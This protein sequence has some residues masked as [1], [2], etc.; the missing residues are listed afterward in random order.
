MFRALPEGKLA[1][2]TEKDVKG[3]VYSID[4]IAGKVLA[5]INSRVHIFSWS[6]TQGTESKYARSLI[7]HCEHQGHILALRVA[8][9]GELIAVGDLMK[10]V[11]LLAYRP[12]EQ[13]IEEVAR[14]YQPGWVAS[15]CPVSDDTFLVAE[16]A[17]NVF[18]LTRNVEAE[19]DDERS[20]LALSAEYHIGEFVNAL[21]P[22]SLV[23]RDPPAAASLDAALPTSTF[24]WGSSSGAV[25]V[26]ARINAD[27][28]Q[29]FSKVQEN[30]SKVIQGVG[31][32]SHSFWRSFSNERKTAPAKNFLDGDLIESFL[33]LRPEKQAIVV[34]G[35]GVSVEDLC[36]R[37]EAIQRATH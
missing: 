21:R 11:T 30:I 24:I 37:I 10:S 3:A 29:F 16:N 35:L 1:L 28:F 9:V 34:S 31:G 4:Q 20:R 36:K 14:D 6:E 8:A 5:A 7:S 13:R 17:Y 23:A 15:L 18:C 32:F 19:T 25:G 26:I 33:D 22:G 27:L 2:V 12:G